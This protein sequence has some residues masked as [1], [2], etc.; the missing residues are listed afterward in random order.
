MRPAGRRCSRQSCL[1]S[2]LLTSL[3]LLHLLQ[4]DVLEPQQQ[5]G[6]AL[7]TPDYLASLVARYE[8]EG[9]EDIV[10]PAIEGAAQRPVAPNF[11]ANPFPL[12]FLI[13]GSLS[14]WQAFAL[15]LCSCLWRGAGRG[16]VC[17]PLI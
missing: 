16:A 4:L 5:G 15:R 11:R 7:A 10:G 17:S 9:L 8:S 1:V 14:P 6:P 2:P 13:C 12:G 3:C